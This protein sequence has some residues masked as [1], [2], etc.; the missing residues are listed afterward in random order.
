MALSFPLSLA[1]FA[2]RLMIETATF[3][4]S[5]NDQVSGLGNGQ[6]LNAEL[7]SPLWRVDVTTYAHKNDDAEALAALIEVLGH[8]GRDFYIYNPRKASPREDPGGSILGGATPSIQSIA[9]NNRQVR[10]QGLTGGYVLSAG[11]MSAFEYGPSGQKRRAVHRL[12]ETVT[13]NGSGLTPLVE[14]YPHIRTGAA[15]GDPVTLIKPAL[16][17]KLIPGTFRQTQV[18]PLHQRLSFSAIQKLI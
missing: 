11:D 17:A 9:T 12:L 4:L 2:D 5:R 18:G 8:P 7:A 13:A 15:E 16:R 1:A 6:P 14:V 10:I 3:S